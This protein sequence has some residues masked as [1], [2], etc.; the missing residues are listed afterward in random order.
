MSSEPSVFTEQ[1]E[2][3]RFFADCWTCVKSYPFVLLCLIVYLIWMVLVF[4]SSTLLP[5]LHWFELELPGWLLPMTAMALVAFVLA[6]LF[7][8]TKFVFTSLRYFLTIAVLMTAG[9]ICCAFWIWGGLPGSGSFVLYL[10]GSLFLGAATAFYYIEVNR[11]LG[12]LGM[13]RTVFLIIVAMVIS[14]LFVLTI[15][16]LPLW[17]KTVLLL[18][19]P[20]L[21]MGLYLKAIYGFEKQAYFQHGRYAKLYFPWKF[22]ITSFMQG[23]VLG[24]IGSSLLLMRIEQVDIV[25]NA[26]GCIIAALLFMLI[27]V[28]IRLDFNKL[29]YQA[30]FTCMAIGLYI[31]W[32][33]L[34]DAFLGFFIQTIGYYFV[35]VTL[36]ALGSYLIKNQG[37]PATWIAMGPSCSLFMG[38]M[39]GGFFCIAAN[40]FFA[41]GIGM[42]M[43]AAA[44][45]LLIAA[46]LLS[47][48]NNFKYGWGTL[49]PVADNSE[50]DRIIR[51]SK[52]LEQEYSLTKRQVEVLVLLA[53]GYARKQVADALFVSEDTVKTHV[54]GLYQ[55]LSIHSQSELLELMTVTAATL[56]LED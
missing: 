27:I 42:V 56:K 8:F 51:I 10:V 11:L 38:T 18:A 14:S 23:A 17:G 29:I 49:R 13:R 55:K 2:Q 26:F 41:E 4:Q 46:L 32:L 33:L 9:S 35:D 37:L 25:P 6:T 21:M 48:E 40:W 5:S 44:I 22:L 20:A 36:W 7:W 28:F 53:K 1:K 12:H 45:I 34:P 50:T 39:I 15:S 43:N 47:N 19:L 24:V 54:R 52:Y 16:L 31:A 30:G 3:R